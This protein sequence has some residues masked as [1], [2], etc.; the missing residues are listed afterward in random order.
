LTEPHC[1]KCGTR[2]HSTLIE[3]KARPVCPACSFTVYLDPKLAVAVV[4]EQ[5]GLI[6]LGLRGQGTREPGKWSFPAGFVDRGE[7]V[8]SAARR[9]I[10][11]ETG[12]ELGDLALLDLISRDGEAVVLAVFAAKTWTGEPSP[13]DDLEQVA[14]FDPGIPP[15]LAFSHDLDV[16]RMW[17]D[18]FSE[19]S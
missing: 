18:W 6:L 8:R 13:G 11:E 19:D 5:S 2:T 1:P 4:I 7:D 16:I 9:E 10:R 12:I 3:G 14:W 15:D 17:S